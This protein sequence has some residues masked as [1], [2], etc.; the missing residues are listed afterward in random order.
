MAPSPA[1]EGLYL[2]GFSAANAGLDMGDWPSPKRWAG[3]PSRWRAR[4]ASC[5][6]SEGRPVVLTIPGDYVYPEARKALEAG[7]ML[8][9]QQQRPPRTGAGAQAAGPAARPAGDGAGLRDEHPGWRGIGFANAVRRGTIGV[10][11]PSGTGLQEFTCQIH[12]AGG[13]VRTPSE[14]AATTC[15]TTSAGRR[16]Y[17]LSRLSSATRRPK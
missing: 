7:L 2:P 11:G 3:E 17:R 5:P 13:G 15:R 8:H 6:W 16:P 4:Q 9:L 14:R 10:I 12:H 1:V